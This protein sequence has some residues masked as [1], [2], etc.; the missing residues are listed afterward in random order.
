MF[1]KSIPK[2]QIVIIFLEG[3]SLGLLLQP[4]GLF[5]IFVLAVGY[6]FVLFFNFSGFF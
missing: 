4:R 3:Y 5:E 1:F 2:F 6:S